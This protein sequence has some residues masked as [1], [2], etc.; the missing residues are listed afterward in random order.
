MPLNK[1]KGEK[2]MFW[3]LRILA[4]IAALNFA[5]AVSLCS[6]QVLGPAAPV[7]TQRNDTNRTSVYAQEGFGTGLLAPGNGW[8]LLGKLPIDGVVYA[9]PLY[10]PGLTITGE[11]N[12]ALMEV[13]QIRG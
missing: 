9:Q 1:R 12:N 7:L 11:A 4:A 2:K 13:L 6:A 5:V 3:Q 10:A 8:K